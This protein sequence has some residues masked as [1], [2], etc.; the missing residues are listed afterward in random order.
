MQKKRESQNTVEYLL[1][2]KLCLVDLAGSERVKDSGVTGVHLQEA[3][4]INTS[5]T[6]LGRVISILAKEKSEFVPFRDS[7]LTWMLKDI[8]GGNSKTVMM[9]TISPSHVHFEETLSTLKYAYRTKQIVNRIRINTIKDKV[10]ILKLREELEALNVKW[11]K[12]H[13]TTLSHVN[14]PIQ[15]DILQQDKL[16]WDHVVEESKELQKKSIEKYQEQFNIVRDSLQ[17]PFLLMVSEPTIGQELMYYVKPGTMCASV[18]DPNFTCKFFHDIATGVWLV[19]MDTAQ[20]VLLNDID[21]EDEPH[22]LSHGDKITIDTTILKFKIPIC[23]I[24]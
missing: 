6:A 17:L 16:K 8:M 20:T 14:E 18:I 22:Q 15:S 11:T 3:S 21:I 10:V 24:K 23:A 5:L 12:F 4:N 9:A 7:S 2:N 1:Q 13:N 19:P